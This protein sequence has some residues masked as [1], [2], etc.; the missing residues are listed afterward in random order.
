V[1]G[2][3]IPLPW[4]QA[5]WLELTSLTLQQRLSHALLLTGPAGI[6][7]RHFARALAA[8][9]LCESRSGYACGK[10]RS[11][12][13]LA[14]GSHPNASVLSPHGFLGLALTVDGHHEGGLVHWQPDEDRKKR[15]ISI[16]AARQMIERMTL[17]NHYGGSKVII[18]D[19]AEALNTNSVNALLKTIEEPPAKTHLLLVSER[20]QSLTATLRSRCQQIRFG[21]PSEDE[22]RA[23]LQQAGVSDIDVLQDVLGAPLRALE[24]A[25]GDGLALRREWT[26]LWTAVAKQ[27]R[28][29]L[30]A[31][32]AVGKEQIAEH[33]RWA[34]TWLI[35]LLRAAVRDGAGERSAA[36]EQMLAE[37]IEAQ[38][39]AT[40]N[41]QPQLLMESLLVQWLR[42]GRHGLAA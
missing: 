5:L 22:S 37:V 10:C 9:L 25:S 32:V 40:G 12:M 26:E 2:L 27:R 6:G 8:F 3:S 24:L 4:Q 34:S 1:S 35:G 23:W 19:P 31:A 39:R 38:R 17:S 16:E 7:K 20:P 29:P 36:L 33:L 18:I 13:Q 28:D 42:L 11:C 14:V 30:S 41:A 21:A 15:D